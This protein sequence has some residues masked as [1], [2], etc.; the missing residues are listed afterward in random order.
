MTWPFGGLPLGG[1]FLGQ[2]DGPLVELARLGGPLLITAG[3]WAG[4][5]AVATFVVWLRGRRARTGGPAVVGAAAAAAGVVALVVAGA[6]AP[7]GGAPVADVAGRARPG[8]RAAGAQQGAGLADLGLRGPAGGDRPG[9]HRPPLPGARPVAR[10]RRG[11]RPSAGRL[12]GGRA[13]RPAGRPARHDARR[14]R[15]RAGVG[16]HLPQRDRG[17]GPPGTRRGHLREGAPGA[18][19]RVRAVPLLLLAPRRSLGRADRRRPRSRH[20]PPAHPRRSARPPGVLR[21]LLRRAQPRLGAGRR[22]VAGR[23]HQHLVVQHVPGAD[24]GDRGGGRAGG[25]DGPRPRPGRSDRL[26]RRGHPAGCGG[27]SAACSAGARC[28]RPPSPCA[29]A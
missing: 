15:H 23:A 5:V 28:S 10:G 21:D 3:V 1:V 8:R 11:P 6:A 27:R 14:R 17:L 25:R 18:L 7:D 13:A 29:A 26:Q 24:A 19:R 20:R 2:A 4:G 9:R 12:P 22:R 16:H